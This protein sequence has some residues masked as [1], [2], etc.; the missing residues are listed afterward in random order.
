MS[1]VI[2]VTPL[3]ACQDS[4][5]KGTF[6]AEPLGQSPLGKTP[7]LRFSLGFSLPRRSAN[8]C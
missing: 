7:L 4:V 3:P 1:A 8:I 5:L 2:F 6:R